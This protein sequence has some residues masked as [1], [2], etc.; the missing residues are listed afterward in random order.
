VQGIIWEPDCHPADID[1]EP[2]STDII[3]LL[4]ERI[5]DHAIGMVVAS[6]SSVLSLRPGDLV[7]FPMLD[8][9]DRSPSCLHGFA[10]VPSDGQLFV[11]IPLAEY[12][13]DFVDWTAAMPLGKPVERTEVGFSRA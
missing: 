11:R 4:R 7:R 5:G 1:L 3:V 10:K 12:N 13:A 9:T 6:G 8:A 2:S